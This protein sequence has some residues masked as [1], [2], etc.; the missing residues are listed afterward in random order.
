M[1]A[2]E[3]AYLALVVVAW[4]AFGLVLFWASMETS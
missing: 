1:T 4:L 3:E 2:G